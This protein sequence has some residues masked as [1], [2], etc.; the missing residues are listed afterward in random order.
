MSDTLMFIVA[1]GVAILLLVGLVLLRT[2]SKGKA[3]VRITDAAIAI[4][5][6]IIILLVTGKITKL[7]V[8]ADG[9]TVETAREAILSASKGSVKL[10]IDRVVPQRLAVASKRGSD[11]I[12]EYVARGVQALK[13]QIGSGVYAPS[14]MKAYFDALSKSPQFKY[15][16]LEQRNGTFF[17]I[18]DARKL[19][20]VLSASER[21]SGVGPIRSWQDLRTAIARSPSKF[22][23]FPSFVSAQ[24]ALP[25]GSSKRKALQRLQKENRE[26]LP[27]MN[28]QKRFVGIIDRSRLTAGLILDVTKQLE[29]G[30]KKTK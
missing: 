24:R 7:G 2:L 12:P 22:R 8:G 25:S 6:I 14:V 11:R 1:C 18:I 26:W 3:E 15:M 17:G 30:N 28:A 10:Q 5:P 21:G 16:V 13:F 20:S 27:V 23:S 29:E 19:L 4:L 9:V